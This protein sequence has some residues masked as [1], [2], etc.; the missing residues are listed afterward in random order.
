MYEINVK[1]LQCFTKIILSRCPTRRAEKQK[2]T[3]PTTLVECGD[4][5]VPVAHLFQHL[6]LFP[7]HV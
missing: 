6:L 1:V 4:E 5:A 7:D 2:L 3:A